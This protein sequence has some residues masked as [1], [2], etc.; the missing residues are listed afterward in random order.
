M[1]P[2]IF[3]TAITA[4]VFLTAGQLVT[5]RSMMLTNRR[6]IPYGRF[7]AIFIPGV[8]AIAI[9]FFLWLGLMQKIN[10][11]LSQQ[12]AFDTVAQVLLV[13]AA[14]LFLHERLNVRSWLGI[15]LICVG[16]VLISLS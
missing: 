5:K 7:L 3:A 8:A 6:R 14:V 4:E 1:T 11:N 13:L 10:F 12:Y 2:L 9:Y 15:F 16:I